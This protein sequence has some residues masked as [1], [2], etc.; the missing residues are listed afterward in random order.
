MPSATTT[1]TANPRELYDVIIIGGSYAGLSAAL[2]LYRA[3]HKCLIFDSGIPRNALSTKTRLTSGWEGQDPQKMRDTSKAELE[4]SGL[5]DFI[6]LPVQ[7]AKKNSDG[8]FEVVDSDCETWRGRKILF[9]TGVQEIYPEL[10]GYAENYGTSIYYCMFCFGYEQRGSRS[11]G[12]IAVGPLAHPGHAITNAQDALKFA[13]CVTI[14]T[15]NNPSLAEELSK[16]L[17]G[18]LRVNDQ[19]LKR[20]F[21]EQDSDDISVEFESGE[22]QSLSFLVHKPDLEV[23]TALPAQLGVE[24]TPGLGINVIPPFNKTTVDGVYAAGDCCSPLRMIP[25][26]LSMGAFAGCGLARE[27]PRVVREI[28]DQNGATKVN[29]SVG[30]A[31]SLFIET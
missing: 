21:K 13:K 19:K 26:A 6:P 12:L 3:T 25:N 27:L 29:G 1:V 17:E 23:N 7:K 18:G 15:N 5:V 8:T 31:E 9:S 30:I 2:T 10:E 11:A 4:G 20:L 22:K 28:K 14:Y 16:K 24:C